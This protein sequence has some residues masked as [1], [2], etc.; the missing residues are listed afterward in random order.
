LSPV[1]AEEALA[2]G[3]VEARRMRAAGLIEAAGM[4]LEDARCIEGAFHAKT[5]TE[6]ADELERKVVVNG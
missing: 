5:T 4:F 3:V 6:L 1:E 2:R